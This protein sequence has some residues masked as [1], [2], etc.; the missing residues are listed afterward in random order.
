MHKLKYC[1]NKINTENNEVTRNNKLH[2]GH[3][4]LKE[5]VLNNNATITFFFLNKYYF[6]FFPLI[7][8]CFDPEFHFSESR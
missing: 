3:K 7:L 6:L 1:S 4:N 8:R 2:Y 5:N